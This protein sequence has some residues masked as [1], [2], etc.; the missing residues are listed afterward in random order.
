VVVVCFLF[1]GF[2]A[3]QRQASAQGELAVT[4][5]VA[6]SV[7]VLLGDN[8]EQ[9][10]VVANAPA[11]RTLLLALSSIKLSTPPKASPPPPVVA[12]TPSTTRS[13]Q[14]HQGKKDVSP[15]GK[16]SQH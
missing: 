7:T 11:D 9:T 4:V 15:K 3:A 8:G 12:G 5:N 16:P 2:A 10:L 1:T 13:R 6:S 14:Y